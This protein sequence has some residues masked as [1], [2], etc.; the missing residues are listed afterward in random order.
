MGF[1]IQ[2]P[3][4]C[5]AQYIVSEYDG[6]IIPC[7]NAFSEIPQDKALLCVV[8]NGPFEAAA[9]CFSEREFEAFTESTDERRKTWLIMDKQKVHELTGYKE[10]PAKVC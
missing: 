6:K 7:P 10:R 5:K 3:A 1:Y 4:L 2:G 9:Y 8:N